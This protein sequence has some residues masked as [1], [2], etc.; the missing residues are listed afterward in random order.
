MIRSAS[1]VLSI[2]VLL[3]HPSAARAGERTIT[4]TLTDAAGQ[5][6]SG[7][8]ADALVVVENG[9]AREI[10]SVAPDTRPL[11]LALLVDTSA[12][13]G[14]SYRL[15]LLQPLVRF[16]ATLPEGSRY[17]LWT[18]GDRPVKVVDWSD[19]PKEA[20]KALKLAH[21]Q[22]GNT[23]LDAIIE[24][25]KDLKSREG[26]RSA[27]VA[28]AG[29][30]TDFSNVPRERM[31]EDAAPRADLFYFVQF[32][33]G[34]GS[35]EGR[36]SVDYALDGLVSKSGGLLERPLTALSVDA[37]LKKISSD[38]NGQYRITYDSVDEAKQRKISVT[39]AQPGAK[40][41]VAA[42]KSR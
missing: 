34:D 21:P 4:V 18:T 12:A 7:I 28:V 30:G 6:L 20:E 27:V 8:S 23:L 16:L 37:S 15:N 32:Q 42:G 31:V 17:S 2:L 41:R 19:D 13:V 10:S 14:P 9:V 22:G 38:L 25:S 39:V 26:A 24:A 33:E 40:V 5:R 11:S 1:V 36:S 3:E 29:I 35:S